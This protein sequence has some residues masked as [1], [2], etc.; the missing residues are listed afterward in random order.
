MLGITSV[1][2]VLS[3]NENQVHCWDTPQR[4]PSMTLVSFHPDQISKVYRA[5]FFM[6]QILVLA[7]LGGVSIKKDNIRKGK[8]QDPKG[9]ICTTGELTLRKDI[10]SVKVNL[11]DYHEYIKELFIKFPNLISPEETDDVAEKTGGDHAGN[12]KTGGESKRGGLD[13]KK[14]GMD[15]K[16]CTESPTLEEENNNHGNI[17]ACDDKKVENL[18]DESTLG[19]TTTISPGLQLLIIKK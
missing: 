13:M 1:P 14:D 6:V 3:K 12:N 19:L 18:N 16:S 8:I 7:T 9:D 10:H 4:P 15:N 2:S 5:I 17:T 11:E